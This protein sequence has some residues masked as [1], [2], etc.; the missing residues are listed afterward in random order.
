MQEQTDQ[1]QDIADKTQKSFESSRQQSEALL[2]AVQSLSQEIGPNGNAASRGARSSEIMS[3]AD[4]PWVGVDFV[5][6]S[7][8][9]PN[10]RLIVTATVRNSA[11]TP[12]LN[13]KVA[14]KASVSP[15]Q[16]DD[17]AKVDECTTC[18]QTV[19][20][21]NMGVNADVNFDSGLLTFARVNRV[22]AGEETI[23]LT[24][25]INY[26]DLLARPHATRV[27]MSYVPKTSTFSACLDGN[28]FD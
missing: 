26:K 20:L 28:H 12:A 15:P 11:R 24:G 5:T 17:G 27:C 9:V 4:R 3:D 16:P 2:K 19:L 18:P 1:L 7:P 21:P 22:K 8:L 13:V 10:T 23:W 14:L 25:R 6:T